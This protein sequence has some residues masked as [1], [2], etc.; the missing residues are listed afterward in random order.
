MTI[1]GASIK[2]KVV[3]EDKEEEVAEEEM[4]EV[5]EGGSVKDGQQKVMS[6]VIRKVLHAEEKI[7][8]EQRENFFHIMVRV[9]SRCCGVTINR[10]SYTNVASASMVQKFNLATAY[11]SILGISTRMKFYAMWYQSVL[12]AYC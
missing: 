12:A 5:G 8:N 11:L 4:K 6:L 7:E 2:I 1:R 9:A 3:S 10:G